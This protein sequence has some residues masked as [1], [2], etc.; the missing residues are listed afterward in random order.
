[1]SLKSEHSSHPT[2]GIKQV[3]QITLGQGPEKSEDE[4]AR[5]GGGRRR[6]AV[7]RAIES[8][9]AAVLD[10]GGGC[11]ACVV[12]DAVVG[13]DDVAGVVAVPLHPLLHAAALRRAAV[14]VP[15]RT[16]VCMHNYISISID[17][18]NIP[19]RFYF[20]FVAFLLVA[21]MFWEFILTIFQVNIWVYL[22]FGLLLTAF[23]P[24]FLHLNPSSKIS[25]SD[26]VLNPILPSL[27][28]PPPPSHHLLMDEMKSP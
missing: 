24:Y 11:G 7:R 8:A 3:D 23:L 28:S 16:Y 21:F 17:P 6:A 15:A 25:T 13:G 19:F 27:F 5:V 26:L 1:M 10:D 20:F 18:V 2:T 4:G 12:V 14:V 22:G 9:A